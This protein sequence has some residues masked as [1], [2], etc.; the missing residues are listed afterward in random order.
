[1]MNYSQESMHKYLLLNELNELARENVIIIASRNDLPT[2]LTR[3]GTN[4]IKYMR[5]DRFILIFFSFPFRN[6]SH[7]G[8]SLN[9]LLLNTILV[10]YH[11]IN[12]P[13][14]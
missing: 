10:I 7:N 14:M 5:L 6:F 9:K 12:H 3:E 1:M 8:E 4:S 11:C 13:K 2:L